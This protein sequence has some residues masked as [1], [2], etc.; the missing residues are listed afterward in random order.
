MWFAIEKIKL[1]KADLLG[2]AKSTLTLL[3]H[4]G[5]GG[6]SIHCDEQKLGRLHGVD[7]ILQVR[8]NGHHH[9]LCEKQSRHQTKNR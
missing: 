3:I 8:E 4:L 5:A 9:F 1:K 2:G 6:N 7:K